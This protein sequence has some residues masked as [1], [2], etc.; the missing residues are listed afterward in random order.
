MGAGALV[1]LYAVG[2]QDEFLHLPED[3]SAAGPSAAA[4]AAEAKHARRPSP[5][6]QV[7][8]RPTNFAVEPVDQVFD[9]RVDY[10]RRVACRL[11]RLGDLISGM[12][13]QIVLRRGDASTLAPFFPAEQLVRSVELEIGGVRVDQRT[14]DWMRLRYELF[15]T[16]EQKMA[17]RRMT[18]FVDDEPPGTLKTFFLPLDMYFTSALPLSL[19]M[20]ALHHMEA[21]IYITFERADSMRGVDLSFKPEVTLWCDYVL[22]DKAER[23]FLAHT[24]R[25]SARASTRRAWA[26]RRAW[27]WPSTTP[28]AGW[29]GR[30]RAPS[31]GSSRP[32]SPATP[33]RPWRPWSRRCCWSTARS[34]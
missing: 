19:P 18:D 29:P 23:L 13:L 4:S 9:G 24:S 31:T 6:R 3:A 1:Q 25:C 20:V 34:A 15:S 28:C 27:P 12:C 21:T 26:R 32:A 10:G 16:L 33:P 22:L 8:V 2:K 11:G 5:W 17:Y 7:F 30:P 14:S